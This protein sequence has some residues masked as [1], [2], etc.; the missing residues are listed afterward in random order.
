M[1]NLIHA[2]DQILETLAWRPF[3]LCEDEVA[4][5]DRFYQVMQLAVTITDPQDAKDAIYSF[6]QER[7]HDMS[8]RLALEMDDKADDADRREAH[9]RRIA[10][11]LGKL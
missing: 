10:E 7:I 9:D 4:D 8:H 3:D 6:I 5:A 2:K 1:D 11:I